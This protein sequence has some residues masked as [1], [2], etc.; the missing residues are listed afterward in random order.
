MA[1]KKDNNSGDK[2]APPTIRN[3]KAFHD[4]TFSEKVEAGLV[5]TGTEVKSLRAGHCELRESYA[6]LSGGEVWVEGMNI[7]LYPQAVGELQHDPLRKRKAL[8]HKRQI[9]QLERAVSQK[10]NA[11]I[12]LR[13]YFNHGYAKIEIGI[14]QGK[15][16]FDKRESLKKRQAQRD[17]DR[18]AKRYR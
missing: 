11:L 6:R 1:K 7:A 15:R 9:A 17:I 14:G 5:L 3:R 4:Y 2:S 18:E 8:L 12:P 16:L 13:V 10:G